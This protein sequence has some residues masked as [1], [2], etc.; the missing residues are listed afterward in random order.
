MTRRA[1]L[2]MILP[3]LLLSASP[4]IA[5]G[6]EGVEET[7][8][9]RVISY[10]CWAI[11]GYSDAVDERVRRIGPALAALEPDVVCLQEVWTPDDGQRILDALAEAGLP[12]ARHFRAPLEPYTLFASGMLIASRYPFL[13]E[14]VVTPFRMRGKPHAPWH[15]D[16]FASKGVA[17]VVVDT[18]LGPVRV[19]DTHLH[20]RYG[21]LEY[22][23]VQVTQMLQAIDWL[24]PWGEQDMPPGELPLLLLGDLNSRRDTVTM[25]L[26]C[27]GTGLRP[28]SEELAPELGIDWVLV[29]DGD[30]LGLRWLAVRH[31]LTEDVD[32]GLQVAAQPLADHPAVVADLE[33]FRRQGRPAPDLAAFGAAV[34]AARAPVVEERQASSRRWVFALLRT[35]GWLA[36]LG[37]VVVLGR[38]IRRGRAAL[39]VLG[40]A[41][42][43]LIV[44]ELYSL[45][46]FE[47][48][49]QVCLDRA[50]DRLPG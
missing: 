24:G 41:L 21:T 8:P 28:P 31:A 11:P 46:V 50:L 20:A 45:V 25:G 16:A 33:L 18:P 47:P 38:R 7:L 3:L 49:W 2:S 48:W 42:G 5:Q 22:V 43:L 6:S 14:P 40:V 37:G 30:G 35:L 39:V 27:A 15:A 17:R 1:L 4:A 13:E 29:R 34:A 9:L 32:L 26:L 44:C 10:N 23:P 12:H 36:L 19:A